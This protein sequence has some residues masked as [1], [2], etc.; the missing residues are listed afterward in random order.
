MSRVL[1]IFGSIL[2][3]VGILWQYI[4]KLNLGNLPGDIVF[5]RNDFSFYFPIMTCIILSIIVSL[6][7]WIVNKF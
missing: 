2:I 3:L 6:I 1:I 4:K 5:K 7:F